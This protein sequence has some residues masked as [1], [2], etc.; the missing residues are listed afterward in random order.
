MQIISLL[1]GETKSIERP[2]LGMAASDDRL[3][4]YCGRRLLELVRYLEAQGPAPQA[5]GCLLTRQLY[6]SPIDE[7]DSGDA[8][9]LTIW[10]DWQDYPAWNDGN[11]K[12]HYRLQINRKSRVLTEDAR[13]S[14]PEEVENVIRGAFNWIG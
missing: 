7:R 6:L 8:V 11:P 9:S 14:T 5:F 4:A 12:T 13:A 1:D 3:E 10:V 2:L